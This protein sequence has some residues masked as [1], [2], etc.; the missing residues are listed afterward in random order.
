MLELL[1]IALGVL[2][3]STYCF[4]RY[5]VIPPLV[6]WAVGPET[7]ANAA[8]VYGFTLWLVVKTWATESHSIRYVREG[9]ER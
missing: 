9:D 4:W 3:I 8:I 5:V 7:W 2:L 1:K 6:T